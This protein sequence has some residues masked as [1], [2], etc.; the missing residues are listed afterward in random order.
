MCTGQYARHEGAEAF[1]VL[2]VDRHNAGASQMAE[3]IGRTLNQ[4]NFVFASAGIEPRPLDSRVVG[5]MQGKGLDIS[6]GVP[7]AV[8][9]MPNLT[10]FPIII[11]LDPAAR[12]AFPLRTHKLTFIDWDM[13]DPALATG[14]A[15][16]VA[17]ACEAAYTFLKEQITDL[18]NAI[19]VEGNT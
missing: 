3:A 13:R 8:S 12:E 5:W 7:R 17:A 4:P 15:E 2:F 14:N 1:S 10:R 11:I 9:E 19:V 18:V 6:R 16:E